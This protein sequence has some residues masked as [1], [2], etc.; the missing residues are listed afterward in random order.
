M[1][2]DIVDTMEVVVA[3]SDNCVEKTNK[4][5]R[6]IRIFDKSAKFGSG[7]HRDKFQLAHKFPPPPQPH[8]LF[9]N[10][11]GYITYAVCCC[12][13]LRLLREQVVTQNR[14]MWLLVYYERD[15]N[16]SYNYLRKLAE[17]FKRISAQSYT[18]VNFLLPS[19]EMVLPKI[20]LLFPNRVV[21]F[22]TQPVCVCVCV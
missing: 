14:L 4:T 10:S 7:Y 22:L 5:T 16:S 20:T 13:P 3:D 1:A 6:N 9:I 19:S 18:T 15:L 12:Y 2:V 8:A 21:V 11:L 17:Q